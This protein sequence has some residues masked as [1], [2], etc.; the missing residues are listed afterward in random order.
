METLSRTG[1]FE[2]HRALGARFLPFAGW[3]MPLSYSGVT[4]EHLAVRKGVGL[5]DISHMGRFEIE[6]K[7]AEVLLQTTTCGPLKKL[8]PR[9]AQYSFL[10]NE[11]G[12]I[13]DDIYIY[14]RG[15]E[16]FFVIVNAANRGKD[17]QWL[18][19]HAEGVSVVDRTE[20]T[21]LVA[22][23]GPR[24]WDVLVKVIPFGKEEIVLRHFLDTHAC[25]VKALVARTGYTGERGY[26]I[27]VAASDAQALW[28]GLMEAGRDEGIKPVGL[29][30]RDTLRLEMG[31]LLWGHDIDKSTT[32]MEAGMERFVDF[33]REFIGK[34]TLAERK[35]ERKLIGFELLAGGVPREGCLIFSEEK[36][37]GRVTS[38]NMSPMLRKGI[39]LGYVRTDFAAEGSEILIDIRGKAVPAVIAVPPFYK[40]RP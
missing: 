5:F 37:I 3:E 8:A 18:L 11:S 2:R 16:S 19:S 7:G 35:A 40:K 39:G 21:A 27:A 17:F 20:Q 22:L 33:S 36:E 29:G 4:D 26:E 23:Q 38:G 6:G 32:P 30:A 31:Y 15:K 13:I 25:G 28:D 1:L 24:S 12:G 14:R 10:L 34:G 9:S